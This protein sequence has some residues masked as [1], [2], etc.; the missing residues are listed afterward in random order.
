MTRSVVNNFDE[1]AS[2]RKTMDGLIFSRWKKSILVSLMMKIMKA[3]ET[4]SPRFIEYDQ[5]NDASPRSDSNK[6]FFGAVA[7][8]N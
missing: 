3:H 8:S 4:Y 1:E 5:L 7:V 6:R 2:S